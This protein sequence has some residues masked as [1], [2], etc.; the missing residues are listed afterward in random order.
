MFVI[1]STYCPKQEAPRK[2]AL[3]RH[4]GHQV[5]LKLAVSLNGTVLPV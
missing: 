3:A 5:F 1:G 4:I 2:M